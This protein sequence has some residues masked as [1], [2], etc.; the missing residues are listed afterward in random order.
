MALL[1]FDCD[2]V[3]VDSE[4]LANEL[5]AE[6]MTELGHPMG[7]AEAIQK[8]VGRSLPD[9][10]ALCEGVLGCK[11]PDGV[12][13]RYSRRLLER[14]RCDLKAVVGVKAAIAN[15]PYRRCVASSSSI[16]RVRLS[17]EVTSL[18]ALFDGNIFSATQVIR[19][20][21]APELYLLAARMMGVVPDHCIVIEDSPI[22]VTAAVSAGMT[23]IGFVG[24]AHATNNLTQRLLAAG[25]RR[26]FLSMSHLP[27]IIAELT[28]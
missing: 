8:F 25:A 18:L 20:K 11:V 1:I 28:V 6:M 15:L 2:G 23:A 14:L 3:L 19:G 12:G 9:L 5:L 13:Q 21:P 4:I 16:E 27:T 24:G 10:L 22:G 7:T 26:V 17:L